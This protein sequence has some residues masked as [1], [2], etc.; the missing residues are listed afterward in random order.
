MATFLGAMLARQAVLAFVAVL[1]MAASAGVQLHW[2]YGN[3]VRPP[4]EG[5]EIRVLSVNLRKGRADVQSVI[6]LART[7]AD[8]ITLSELTPGW[9]KQFYAA[10][11]R[12][13]FPHSVLVPAPDAGGI[14]IW[15]RYPLE[16][17]ASLKG[18]SMVAARVTVPGLP[19]AAIVAA[20]H[21]INPLTFYGR[22]FELWR[23]GMATLDTRMIDLAER[24]GAAPVIIAGDFNSTPDMRQ[25]RDLL[26]VGFNDAAAQLGSG[27]APTFPSGRRIPSLVTIDH[28][29][30]R[31][32]TTVS[33]RTVEVPQTD[34]RALA[35][36]IVV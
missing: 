19:D 13:V 2:Y 14:G 5:I 30:T 1:V 11:M 21:V 27:W 10:G 16:S 33:L 3:Q 7:G 34:H 23:A 35:A 31:H 17:I 8:V 25:F 9:V 29:L 6:D 20:V 15:S 36:T 24:A 12:E 4:A 18:G 28:V 26:R 32:A 22:A